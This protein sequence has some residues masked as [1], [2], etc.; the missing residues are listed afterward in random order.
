MSLPQHHTSFSFG[1]GGGVVPSVLVGS[2]VSDRIKGQAYLQETPGRLRLFTQCT[3]G[4]TSLITAVAGASTLVMVSRRTRRCFVMDGV[5]MNMLVG[6]L[7]IFRARISQWVIRGLQ[8]RASSDFRRLT[9]QL[10]F[11]RIMVFS[12]RIACCE[13]HL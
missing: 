12:R 11:V 2:F 9:F 6:V 7:Q 13:R 8:P 10:G 3:Y 5:R 4:K 1:G